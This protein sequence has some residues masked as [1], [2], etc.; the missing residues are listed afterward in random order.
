LWLLSLGSSLSWSCGRL[1]AASGPARALHF[2]ALSVGAGAWDSNK[3][4]KAAGEK[5]LLK[6]DKFPND[7]T[8][9]WV[10]FKTRQDAF[11]D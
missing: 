1:Q 3:E 11:A 4:A 10:D 2:A 5:R 8:T 7:P 9:R 6:I